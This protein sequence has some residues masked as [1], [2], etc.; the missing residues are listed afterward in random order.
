MR[1]HTLQRSLKYAIRR[2]GAYSWYQS[3]AGTDF[4]VDFAMSLG[5]ACRTAHH[6]RVNGFRLSSNPLDWMMSYSL[7][8]ASHL[9]STRFN[10][11]FTD[12]EEDPDK[13]KTNTRYVIDRK[14]NIVDIHH[15]PRNLSLQEAQAQRQEKMQRRIDRLFGNIDQAQT[16]LFVSARTDDQIEFLAFLEDFQR[17]YPNKKAVFLNIRDTDSDQHKTAY[18]SVSDH[19][20]LL[21]HSFRDENRFGADP[22]TNPEAWYGNEKCW[23]NALKRISLSER[24]RAKSHLV[25]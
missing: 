7:D 23:Y 24:L 16:V 13:I 6:L 19:L 5:V 2:S 12:I 21:E 25:V 14:N 20:H 9:F 1:L 15:Y 18:L 11:F 3:I 22:N 8:T 10:D 4:Q 17:M